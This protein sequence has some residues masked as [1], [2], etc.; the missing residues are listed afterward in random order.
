VERYSIA[1]RFLAGYEFGDWAKS[2]FLKRSRGFSISLSEES[3]RGHSALGAKG[4][5]RLVGSLPLIGEI[6]KLY[7]WY[8]E[9]ED[10]IF[11]LEMKAK[12][13]IMIFEEVKE[14]IRCH[15]S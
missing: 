9:Q 8:C 11:L 12:K 15:S 5:R 3:F 14:S 4:K 10:K 6:I 7:S 1:E 13:D 2:E